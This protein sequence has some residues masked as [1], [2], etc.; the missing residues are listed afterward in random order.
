MLPGQA[1]GID[2]RENGVKFQ[3]HRIVA[4]AAIIALLVVIGVVTVPSA[5]ADSVQPM[6]TC[7]YRVMATDGLAV[8]EDPGG[9]FLKWKFYPD[10]V[11]SPSPCLAVY[12]YDRWWR[13]V[14]C[15]CAADGIGWMADEWLRRL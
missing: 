11:S 3:L 10:V 2:R 13:S 6:A 7:Y 15:S 4:R 5:S 1:P 9:L 12:K 8:R 14:N